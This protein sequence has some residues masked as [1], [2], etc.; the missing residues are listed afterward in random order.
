MRRL[1]PVIGFAKT[2][3]GEMVHF[4]TVHTFYFEQGKFFFGVGNF[5]HINHTCCCENQTLVDHHNFLSADHR[6]LYFDQN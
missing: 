5:H 1:G 2:N 6:L 3:F 4:A